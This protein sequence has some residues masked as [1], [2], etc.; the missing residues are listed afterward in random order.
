MPPAPPPPS[1]R[2]RSRAGESA[3]REFD[4]RVAARQM[5]IRESHP[6]LGGLL[7]ALTKEPQSTTAWKIGAEGE[8]RLGARLGKLA[9]PTTLLLHDRRIPG[10]RANIDHLVV[11]P[12][13]ITVIDAKHYRGR[14][15]LRVRR[16]LFRPKV[17]ELYVG[18][19]NC[20]KLVDSVRWQADQVRSAMSEPGMAV[21][22]MLCFVGADWPLIGGALKTRGVDIVWPRRAERLLTRSGPHD[23]AT[24]EIMYT[25][26]I[27]AF[28]PA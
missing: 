26:L 25:R 7:L 14:P 5:R 13:G 28:P 11:T 8:E 27:D 23:K 6:I 2:A 10:T 19:R 12:L 9:S 18:R 1:R 3:R 15:H 22:A 21:A 16:D 17:E 24:V 20:T 4:R